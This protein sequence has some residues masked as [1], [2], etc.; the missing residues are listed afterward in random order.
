[1]VQS[2]RIKTYPVD[3]RPVERGGYSSGVVRVQGVGLPVIEITKPLRQPA[4]HASSP[5]SQA[6]P[7]FA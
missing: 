5:A 4:C 2:A 6:R 1:M 3:T 7:A